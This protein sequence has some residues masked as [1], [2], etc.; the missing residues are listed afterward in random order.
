M[1]MIL[2]VL[3]LLGYIC[4]FWA[5]EPRPL[6]EL[7]Y[8]SGSSL[9]TLGFAMPQSIPQ[10]I[11]AF[12]EASI[13]LVVV[14]LF[15]LLSFVL[16]AGVFATTGSFRDRWHGFVKENLAGHGVFLD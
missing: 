7:F 12:A 11:S 5:L 13:G 8:L 4:L 16:A 2:L 15:G 10:T 6:P 9:L 3:I 14:A 1:P